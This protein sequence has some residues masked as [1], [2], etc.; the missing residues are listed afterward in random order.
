VLVSGSENKQD[1]KQTQGSKDKEKLEKHVL[2]F[3][4]GIE[5]GPSVC[6]GLTRAPLGPPSTE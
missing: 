2:N 4:I 6:V 3:H 1:V 5:P